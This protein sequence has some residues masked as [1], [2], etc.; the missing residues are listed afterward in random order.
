MYSFKMNKVLFLSVI[1]L[2]LSVK[3]SNAAII[4]D[5]SV[6][7]QSKGSFR[8]NDYGYGLS[9]SKNFNL[10]NG[11]ISDKEPYSDYL[12]S[13][14]GVFYNR[15]G[16]KINQNY[17]PYYSFGYGYKMVNIY[18]SGGYV[19]TDFKYQEKD[20][21]SQSLREG[22]GF[23]GGGLSF[24]L[25]SNLK[26]KFDVMNYNLNFRAENSSYDKIKV[27]ITSYV[28]TLGIYF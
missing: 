26:L 6:T 2:V 10:V 22:S 3:E 20:R 27:N 11:I 19:M 14:I 24:R 18:G 1:F 12:Y 16:N 15:F 23:L 5:S 21:D 4:L 8:K 9:I 25:A 28:T 17:G 7:S 13:E